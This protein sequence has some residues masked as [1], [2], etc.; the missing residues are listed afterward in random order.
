MSLRDFGRASQHGI[1]IVNGIRLFEP[2]HPRDSRAE[3]YYLP[4]AIYGSLPG[5]IK[6]DNIAAS[7]MR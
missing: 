5:R 4:L 3:G 1:P 6:S 7:M 2:L